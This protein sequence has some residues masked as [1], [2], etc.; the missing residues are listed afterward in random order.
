[1]DFVYKEKDR[2]V[3]RL[4]SDE[5]IEFVD[6]DEKWLINCKSSLNGEIKNDGSI[7]DSLYWFFEDMLKAYIRYNLEKQLKEYKE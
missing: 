6:V 3:F 7:P 2:Y 5:F 1:M 4:D